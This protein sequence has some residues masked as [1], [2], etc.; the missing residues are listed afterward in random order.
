MSTDEASRSELTP[1]RRLVLGGQVLGVGF[2]PFVQ[3]TASSLE[4]NGR[5]ASRGAQ[6]EIDVQGR[7]DKLEQ[8]TSTIL[9]AGPE[10]A[11]PILIN[12]ETIESPPYPSFSIE[13]DTQFELSK[14]T[15]PLDLGIC[16]S[17]L[18]ELTQSGNRRFRYP[19]IQCPECGPRYSLLEELPYIRKHTTLSSFNMC[20]QCQREYEDSQERRFHAEANSCPV[21]GPQL[22]FS[23]LKRTYNEKDTIL[24]A[25]RLSLKQGNIIA[26]KGDSGYHY[27]CDASNHLAIRRLRLKLRRPAKPFAVIF[28]FQGQD[29][30]EMLREHVT[31]DDEQ[32][33]AL[34]HHSRP[35]VLCKRLKKSTLARMI[36]PGLN[37]IA[38]KLPSNPLHQLMAADFKKPLLF[39]STEYGKDILFLENE[40]VEK[41]LFMI[42]DAFLHHNR[43]VVRLMK[44][45]VV[46]I[47]AGRPRLLRAGRGFA[48]MQL[49]LPFKLSHPILALGT[50]QRNTIALGWDS[51]LVI[52]P[53]TGDLGTSGGALAFESQVSELQE[54]FGVQT[55][56]LAYAADQESHG[57]TWADKLGIAAGAVW[58]S[59]AYA[60]QIATEHNHEA[61]WLVFVW[62]ANCI[63]EN[64]EIWGGDALYGRPDQ[65]ERASSLRPFTLADG[66]K[67]NPDPWRSA[68]SLCWETD[69]IWSHQLENVQS[70]YKVWKQKIQ[71]P[72]STSAGH[73]FDA[74]AA[75]L[76]LCLESSY[77]GQSM[78]YLESACMS[79]EHDGI[80]LPLDRDSDGIWRADWSPLLPM[81]TNS[82]QLVRTRAANFHASL[83]NSIVE[84]AKR[85]R[86]EQGDFAVGL[87]GSLFTNKRLTELSFQALREA[88]FRVYLPQQLPFADG[89]IA[90]GQI[91]ELAHRNQLLQAV[92]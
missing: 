4:L 45:S 2:R 17:C 68:L 46:R 29:G 52:S 11:A 1:T 16:S 76:N 77:S 86:D 90:Y 41:R 50:A 43:P 5:I 59:H 8:F 31:L 74:A 51:R 21:C 66:G 85:I 81:L 23:T 25:V 15:I 44:D 27:I 12:E 40:E 71:T 62:D 92:E 54:M 55:D 10:T 20:P 42:A 35:I 70:L 6:V 47:I 7:P 89:A 18:N 33:Q 64:G 38:V 84:Q 56:R 91:I 39:V 13:A 3:R 80:P 24:D 82:F 32:A 34:V 22:S 53:Q 9:T 19:F 67:S 79:A 36:S 69:H 87:V 65:W 37:E 72:L 73:L 88:G 63:A 26:V 57:Q 14:Q 83:A 49:D 48:P 30:L 28:P 75:L 58:K 78:L 60:S 61:N